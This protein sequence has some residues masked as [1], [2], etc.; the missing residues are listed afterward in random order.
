MKKCKKKIVHGS[1]EPTT[2]AVY[3]KYLPQ[4]ESSFSGPIF[5]NL[6]QT[7]KGRTMLCNPDT[8]LL[9]RLLPFIQHAESVIRRGG[10]A[11][12]ECK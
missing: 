5:S 3:E 2:F 1:L 11:G 12:I 7:S 4:I 10:A 9:S 6:S 8:G